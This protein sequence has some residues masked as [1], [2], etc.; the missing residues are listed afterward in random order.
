[1]RNTRQS[2]TLIEIRTVAHRKRKHHEEAEKTQSHP[3]HLLTTIGHAERGEGTKYSEEGA[4]T[5]LRMKTNGEREG[6]NS[7]KQRNAMKWC[8]FDSRYTDRSHPPQTRC[9]LRRHC[10]TRPP[11][12]RRCRRFRALWPSHSCPRRSCQ[13]CSEESEGSST[14]PSCTFREQRPIGG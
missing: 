7:N 4:K 10:H 9:N 12:P 3:A 8:G 5:R 13:S 6:G 2:G 1:M 14:C 11:L